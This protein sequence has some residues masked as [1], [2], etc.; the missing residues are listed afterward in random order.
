[1]ARMDRAAIDNGLQK[2]SRAMIPMFLVLGLLGA[3]PVADAPTPKPP[4]LRAEVIEALQ[5]SALDGFSGTVT[6]T[7]ESW[8]PPGYD[9]VQ[10]YHQ[11]WEIKTDGY[12]QIRADISFPDSKG[13]PVLSVVESQSRFWMPLS[14]ELL[15]WDKSNPPDSSEDAESA[16]NIMRNI[17][18]QGNQEL[19]WLLGSRARNAT[20][21][22]L[23]LDPDP[24]HTSAVIRLGGKLHQAVF[25]RVDGTLLLA[26]IT[27][28]DTIGTYKWAFSGYRR[29]GQRWISQ[30]VELVEYGR[31]PE[32]KRW[33]YSQITVTH[34]PSAADFQRNFWVPQP[35][36]PGFD[37]II[38]V[39][40][41]SKAFPGQP[42]AV[43]VDSFPRLKTLNGVERG[44]IP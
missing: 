2:E 33:L 31:G 15:V 10:Y 19:Q 43:N 28:N 44:I 22:I 39:R 26:S 34:A 29:A 7:M 17:A 30:T 8:S 37:G 27:Y 32:E 1:M 16:L 42:I 3:D 18:T 6:F 14:S 9:G 4:D 35:G 23:L 38:V 13:A 40:T 11:A 12:G 24:T 21:E 25:H 20:I 5:R 36:E 41:F